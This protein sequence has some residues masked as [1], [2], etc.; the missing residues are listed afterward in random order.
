MAPLAAFIPGSPSRALKCRRAVQSIVQRSAD[1][2]LT[3]R[4]FVD[5]ATVWAIDLYSRAPR[6]AK[7][8]WVGFDSGG[9]WLMSCRTE[10]LQYAHW[11]RPLQ[12]SRI[13]RP[14][15]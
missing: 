9:C 13:T 7:A 1:I 6:C 10:E 15:C 5:L 3:N 2:R 4:D 14:F 8:V 12:S 11:R